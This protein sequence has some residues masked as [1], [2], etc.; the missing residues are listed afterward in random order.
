MRTAVLVDDDI[1]VL[2]MLRNMIDWEAQGYRIL[3]ACEDGEEAAREVD[4]QEVDLLITDIGMPGMD[5]FGLAKCF[6]ERKPEMHVVFLTCY[7]EFDYAREAVRMNADDYLVKYSLTRQQLLDVL[8]KVDQDLEETMETIESLREYSE[9]VKN[10]SNVFKQKLLRRILKNGVERALEEYDSKW[11]LYDVKLPD[12]KFRMGAVFLDPARGGDGQF[13]D[14]DEGCRWEAVERA[15][16]LLESPECVVFPIEDYCIFTYENKL[17]NME[18]PQVFLGRLKKVQQMLLEAY[19]IQGTVCAAGGTFIL[20]EMKK[21]VEELTSMRSLYFYEGGGQMILSGGEAFKKRSLDSLSREY[22]EQFK[23]ML[24]NQDGFPGNFLKM[25]A[26]IRELQCDP[27]PVKKLFQEFYHYLSGLMRE[28]REEDSVLE[29]YFIFDIYAQ[30]VL[31]LYD[32]YMRGRERSWNCAANEDIREILRYVEENLDRPISLQTAADEIHKNSSYL[33]R[34]F[35]Q[36]TGTNFSKY[37]IRKR[38][39]KATFL[40][41][42]TSLPIQEIAESIGI[43]NIYYFYRFYKKESGSTPGDIRQGKGTAHADV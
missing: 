17:W 23:A 34:L 13:G 28:W 15:A 5:G 9:E 16:E 30:Q 33:S 37:L 42:E 21:G 20:E 41:K 11:K 18:L 14:I 8:A 2:E 32:I 7:E 12:G 3:A 1:E 6:R 4:A 39:E 10:N 31:E 24:R 35:K 40:L 22:F 36:S 29:E 38:V 26:V 19:G 27:E 25:C 43:D